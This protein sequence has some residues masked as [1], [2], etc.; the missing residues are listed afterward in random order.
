MQGLHQLIAGNE[1][2]L[3]DRVLRYAKEHGYT[4]YASTLVEAWRG[5]IAGISAPILLSLQVAGSLLAVAADQDFMAD[6]LA[7]FG[8]AEARKHRR[9]GVEFTLFLGLMKYYRKAYH[10]LVLHGDFSGADRER[11]RQILECYFDRIELGFSSEWTMVPEAELLRE[12]QAGTMLMTNEKNKFLTIFESLPSP[13]LFINYHDHLVENMNHPAA[14]L[15]FDASSA[16]GDYYRGAAK[17]PLPRV[18]ADELA[19]FAASREKTIRF[20]KQVQS[21]AGRHDF[22]VLMQK[23]LDVS[24]RFQGYVVICNDIT[25]LKEMEAEIEVLNTDLA[26]RA[27]ELEYANREL[28]AFNYSVSHD[29]RSPLTGINGYCQLLLTTCAEQLD[30]QCKDYVRDIFRTSVRMNQL[31]TTLLNFSRLSKCEIVREQVDLGR[32]A[33]STLA[34]LR[35]NEAGRDVECKVA[36]GVV[37]DGDSRLLQLVMENLLGN[38]WKFTARTEHAVVE[39]DVSSSKGVPVFCVR[40]NGIGFDMKEA[41]NL[42]TPFQRLH[43]YDDY[44]GFGIGLAT[45]DRII[46]RHGGRIWA[47]GQTGAGAAVYFTLPSPAPARFMVPP[48]SRRH[49]NRTS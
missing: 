44:E 48:E 28:E 36:E 5:S 26:A 17:K 41:R 15:F 2:W 24:G 42:F 27:Y 37:V 23:M 3:M 43:S 1:D 21:A 46:R 25:P 4:R 16:G 39:F 32:L 30:D 47:E 7:M 6:P 12:L 34:K 22:I 11:Y 49:D 40:D 8:I 10:D 38:A 20:E 13:V 31:I 18:F 9:R 19:A 45:V 35:V 14:A 33:S 29:L